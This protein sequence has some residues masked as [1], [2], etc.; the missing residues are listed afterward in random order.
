MELRLLAATDLQA[1]VKWMNDVRVNH[2]LN[3]QL[4]VNLE[5][6]WLW[7]ERI[8]TNPLR[9][10]YVFMEDDELVA[11]GGFTD[12]DKNVGKAELYIFVNPEMQGRG[13]GT[14]ACKLMCEHG[15]NKVGLQK[16]YLHTNG[17][18]VAAR[19]LYERLGFKLEGYMQNE[20]INNGKV[21]DR[22]Y[23]ALFNSNIL[24]P[25]PISI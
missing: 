14:K 12:I 21:K 17:D 10:D 15:F 20:I 19:R 4:P 25:P 11:M 1:R 7:F 24:P 18:N 2:T 8:Q 9:E 6:T 3:I 13:I 5:S 22:C 16:I 23:Y